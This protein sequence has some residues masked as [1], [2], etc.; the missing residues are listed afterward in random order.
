MT[1]FPTNWEKITKDPN[2]L[3]IVKSYQLDFIETLL[4]NHPP[5]VPRFA[6]DEI[7][8]KT[9]EVQTMLDKGAMEKTVQSP[10]QFVGHSVLRPKKNSTFRPVFNLKALNRFIRYEHFKMEGMQ[11]LS[12]MLQKGYWGGG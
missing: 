11:M 4:Q 2:I 1:Q 9:V 10:D 5:H 3:Q 6:M 7:Q 8:Q 12:S